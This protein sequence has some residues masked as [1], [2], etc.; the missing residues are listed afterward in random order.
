MWAALQDC[1][2]RKGICIPQPTERACEIRN[3]IGQI[4]PVMDGEK[5]GRDA[6]MGNWR[7]REAARHPRKPRPESGGRTDFPQNA[8]EHV[9]ERVN[10]WFYWT[11]GCCCTGQWKKKGGYDGWDK[12]KHGVAWAHTGS[13]ATARNL[14][15]TNEVTSSPRGPTQEQFLFQSINYKHSPLRQQDTVSSSCSVS[16][17]K[18]TEASKL[19]IWAISLSMT[20]YIQLLKSN[21]NNNCPF[22][23]YKEMQK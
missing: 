5:V 20:Y 8:R 11:W 9:Q 16:A 22:T 7:T 1:R 15:A 13:F 21:N 2:R 12:K 17:C 6:V 18:R 23:C 10:H 4:S 3:E 14:N 19:K